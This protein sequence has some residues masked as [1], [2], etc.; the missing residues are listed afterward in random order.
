[1][2]FLFTLIDNPSNRFDN[3]YLDFLE[4]KSHYHSLLAIKDK[5]ILD[6]IHMSYQIL[7]FRD[8]VVASTIEENLNFLFLDVI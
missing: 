6:T 7:Y 8:C 5:K 2:S 1:M 4:T 3:N